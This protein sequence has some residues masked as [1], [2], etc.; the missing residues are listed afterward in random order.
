MAGVNSNS[1]CWGDYDNDGFADLF[2]GCEHQPSLLYHNKGDGTFEEVAARPAW[3]EKVPTPRRAHLDRFR[4]RRL[5]RICFSINMS[6]YRP[7][8]S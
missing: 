4:Q 8:L 3:L 7:A 5:P 6:E 2:V 1:A